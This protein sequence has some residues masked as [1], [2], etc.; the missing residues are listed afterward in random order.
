MDEKRWKITQS[1]LE[2][3]K[4]ASCPTQPGR[5]LPGDVLEGLLLPKASQTNP[6]AAGREP[7]AQP[8]TR[9]LFWRSVKVWD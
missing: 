1:Y 7:T 3:A 5:S 6:K 9:P 8:T 4:E 2:I